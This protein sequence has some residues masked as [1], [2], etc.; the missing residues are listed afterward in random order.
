MV[1]FVAKIRY[2]HLGRVSTLS[3]STGIEFSKVCGRCYF[4]G[5]NDVDWV[6]DFES[7]SCKIVK[8]TVKNRTL[9][10]CRY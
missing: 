4:F 8:F 7:K 1:R 6:V 3:K 10:I 2:A 5:R 9:Y